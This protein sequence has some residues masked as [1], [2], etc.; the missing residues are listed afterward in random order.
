LNTV[1]VQD[2]S[3]VKTTIGLIDSIRPENTHMSTQ[4]VDGEVTRLDISDTDSMQPQRNI[5]CSSEYVL[6]LGNG[7]RLLFGEIF[8]FSDL[9][10][11]ITDC[12]SL[13]PK[14]DIFHTEDGPEFTNPAFFS[15][16]P[17]HENKDAPWPFMSAGQ[18]S[19][20]PRRE[21]IKGILPANALTAIN[22]PSGEGK[23]FVAIDLMACVAAGIDWHGFR[24]KI[25]GPV[26]YVPGEGLDDIAYR[27]EAWCQTHNLS[28]NNLPFFVSTKVASLAED[29]E[30][31]KLIEGIKFLT[32]KYGPPVIVAFDTLSRNMGPADENSSKDM[33]GIIRASDKLREV[34]NST[35][36]SVH[37]TGLIDKKRG[38][39]SSVFPAALDVNLLLSTHNGVIELSGIKNKTGPSASPLHFKLTQV[40]IGVYDEDGDEVKTC[41]IEPASDFID[42]EAPTPSGPNKIAMDS[43][44]ALQGQGLTPCPSN[45]WRDRAIEMGISSSSQQDAQRKAFNRAKKHLLDR[46]LVVESNGRYEPKQ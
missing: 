23:T 41:I 11:V 20:Q 43:L 6:Q 16:E 27:L 3:L 8:S 28:R 25:P 7:G 42:T 38:R 17:E 35:I 4:H 18:L 44:M 36:L 10:D 34:A 31:N 33:A 29:E 46:G 13:E 9:S 14:E 22:G 39:G 24:V 12:D 2:E 30:L 21:I 5:P 1:T 40:G 15:W 32:A 37:H 45:T 19:L 26:V